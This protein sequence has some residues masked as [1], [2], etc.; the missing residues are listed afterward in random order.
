[1]T[2]DQLVNLERDII[3][4]VMFELSVPTPNNWMNIY[5][6]DFDRYLSKM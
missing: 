1:M 5:A 2:S 6:A 4:T 3:Q